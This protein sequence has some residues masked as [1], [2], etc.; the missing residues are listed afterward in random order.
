MITKKTFKV[1]LYP[2]RLEVLI[3]DTEEEV[4]KKYPIAEDACGFYKSSGDGFFCIGIKSNQGVSTISHE[5]EHVKNRI[6][7]FIGQVTDAH[8]DEVDA[9]LVCWIAK[10]VTDVFYKHKEKTNEKETKI[11]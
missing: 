6:F 7:S 11:K 2:C 3:Y 9:Y 1:P 5:A 4:L 10:T 8:N